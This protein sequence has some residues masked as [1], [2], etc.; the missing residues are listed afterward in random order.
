M[1]SAGDTA[2][3]LHTHTHTHFFISGG[4]GVLWTNWNPKSLNLAKFSFSVEGEGR[5]L[6]TNSN[7]K[8][9]SLAKFHLGGRGILDQVK[10]KGPQSGKVFMG[11]GDTLEKIKPKVPTSLTIFISRGWG[12]GVLWAPHSSN[13]LVGALKEFW[14]KISPSLACSCIFSSGS[15]GWVRGTK[16]HE[17]YAAAFGGHLFYDLFLQGHGPL[18]PPGPATGL[19]HTTCME[20]N[21]AVPWY[22]NA[23]HRTCICDVH[24]T[25]M[26]STF[27]T[28]ELYITKITH[29]KQ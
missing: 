20:T 11:G 7:L 17:I 5:V 22:T 15:S 6:W 4:G 21:K 18:G 23:R 27:V 2:I 13:T 16:K 12:A 28:A 8:S 24:I 14:T 19:S 26:W 10:I 9:L 29:I 1:V 3:I 25:C